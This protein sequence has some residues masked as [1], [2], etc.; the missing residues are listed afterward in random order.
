M[1]Y[2]KKDSLYEFK[3]VTPLSYWRYPED[4]VHPGLSTAAS[5]QYQVCILSPE[6]CILISLSWTDSTI[7]QKKLLH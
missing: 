6:N 1:D 5:N 7:D 3:E 2:Q 4:C